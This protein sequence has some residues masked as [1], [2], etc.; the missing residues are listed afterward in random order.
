[1]KINF[2]YKK[3]KIDFVDGYI[4]KGKLYRC[5]YTRFPTAYGNPAKGCEEVQLYDFRPKE[6]VKASVI[7]LPGLGSRN[8]RFLLWMGTHLATVGVNSTVVILPGNY[9]RVENNSV[10]GRSFLWPDITTMFQFWENAVVDV[11]STIDFLQQRKVWKE[12]NC[13]VGYCLGGMLASMVTSL[14]KRIN[15]T[16]FMTTGGHMPKIIHKSSSTKFIRKL[17]EEGYETKYYLN[18][19]KRLYDIY[20]KQID[21][22]RNMSL[23]QLTSSNMIHPLF[24]IDPIAYAHLLDKNKITFIDAIFDETLPLISRTALYSEVKGAKKY[25]IPT[26]HVSW[27]PFERFLAQ[28]ILLKV[29]INDKKAN[30]IVIKNQK[31]RF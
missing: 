29:N 6:E 21:I 27:L 8:I 1:M 25:I 16:I 22:V 3:A 15:E 11:C 7:I 5:G 24:K 28:Y 18:D 10:S 14:D 17:F 12:N 30:K 2:E 19:K 26:T 23:L 13:L 9:T 4:F 20:N 31:Y